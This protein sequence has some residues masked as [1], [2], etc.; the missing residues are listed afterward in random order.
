MSVTEAERAVL[1]TALTEEIGEDSADILMRSTLP[2]GPDRLATKDDLDTLS[3]QVEG[4]FAVVE[5]EFAKVQGEFANL[6]AK[7]DGGF[8]KVDGEFA[9]MHAKVDGGFAKVQGEF[10]NLHAKV[11]GGFAKME[12]A[13]ALLGAS[14]AEKVAKESRRTMIALAV[15]VMTIWVTLLVAFVTLSV[16]RMREAGVDVFFNVLN[17]LSAPNYILEMHNQGFAPGDVQF[18]AA[19]PLPVVSEHERA[20]AARASAARADAG[21][22]C[23]I[24]HVI[25]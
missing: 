19:S 16:Q 24:I 4:Q 2:Q 3:T 11:D 18:Y 10:A 9:K 6:H 7:V 13:M 14:V 8:A 22:R 21:C 15:A 17:V 1:R 5:G 12:G 20:C 23:G 25:H